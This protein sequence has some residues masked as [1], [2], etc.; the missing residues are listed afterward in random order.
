MF[1]DKFLLSETL[2][3]FDFILARSYKLGYYYIIFELGYLFIVMDLIVALRSRNRRLGSHQRVQ[4]IEMNKTIRDLSNPFNDENFPKNYR[5]PPDMAL[6]L[7][8]QLRP[9]MT[10][11]SLATAIKIEIKVSSI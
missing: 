6:S 10:G 7:I 9:Y 11:G 8:E 2:P 5:L 3:T 1:T 4:T